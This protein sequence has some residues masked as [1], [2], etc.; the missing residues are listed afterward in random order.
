MRDP[1]AVLGVAKTAS[2]AE[3][4]SAFRKLA[5][6][7]HPDAN[8]DDPKTQERFSEI[9]RAYEIVGDEKKRKQFDRGEIDADGRETFQGHPG[10]GYP[11]G[12]PFAGFDGAEA[13]RGPGGFEFRT[14]K[15]DNAEDIISELF[16]SAFSGA[17]RK[18]ADPFAGAGGAR[19]AQ[20]PRGKDIEANLAVS[21]S[22]LLDGG[23]AKLKLP[24]GRTVA[25]NIPKGAI[26][27]QVIRLKEQGLAGPTGHR[28]DLL[29]KIRI[30]AS[31]GIRLDGLDIHADVDVP[32]ETAINGGKVQFVM[33]DG[34]KVALAVAAWTS[35][36]QTLRLKGKGLPDAKGGRGD[37]FAV[38]QIRLPD[39]KREAL[40]ALFKKT[41][42]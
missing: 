2:A 17:R 18:S 28:G 24:D 33:P 1:Y 35:S 4:K 3:I 27:G 30:A 23:K 31:D 34:K 22:D 7:Y 8:K 41:E 37:L 39:D 36:G 14:S 32:L 9:S 10:H 38:L 5:K 42:A 12:N 16:G 19:R 25:V 13:R 40:E 15:T 6:K 20:P 26:D 11:G 21:I 29:A